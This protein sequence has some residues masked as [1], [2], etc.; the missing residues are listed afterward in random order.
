MILE[1]ME[2]YGQFEKEKYVRVQRDGKFV[3]VGTEISKSGEIKLKEA[4]DQ[5]Y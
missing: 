5:F 4:Q 1:V 2:K 3:S